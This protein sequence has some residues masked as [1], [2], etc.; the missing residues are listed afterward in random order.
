MP[1][2]MI[3]RLVIATH[4]KGKLA[5]FRS[6]LAP[7]VA[8][9][10]SA[11]EL[12][13]P[14][15]VED[16]GSFIANALIKARAACAASGLPVLADDSGLCLNALGGNPGV[17]TA[18]WTKRGLEGLAELNEAIGTNPDRGA[19][20]VC[21]LALVYPDGVEQIFEGKVEG[22]FVWPPR[23]ENGFGYDPTFMPHGETRTYAQMSKEEK[24]A[25]SHRRRAFDL[26]TSYLEKQ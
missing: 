4:N 24:G 18:S 25:L 6:F 10:T 7:Y 20:S 15:P 17:E 1:S 9:V 21:V 2:V 22:Q 23:G 19:Q 11:G 8:E 14:E 16:G 12:N 26:F 3:P 13:L 5:E